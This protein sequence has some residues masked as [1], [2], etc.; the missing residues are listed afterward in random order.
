MA[1]KGSIQPFESSSFGMGSGIKFAVA[2]GTTASILPGDLVTK[3]AGAAYV[4][5]GA[6]NTPTTTAKVV[7]VASSFSTETASAVGTVDVIVA[8]SGQL[9]MANIDVAADIDTQAKYN[10]LL[11]TRAVLEYDAANDPSFTMLS[12]DGATYGCVYEYNDISRYPGK[13]VFSFAPNAFYNVT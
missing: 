12:A 9:W 1:F 8:R 6:D 3:V 11:G 10:A 2:S 4:I 13:V 5:K 7:G